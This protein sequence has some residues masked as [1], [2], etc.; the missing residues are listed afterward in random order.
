VAE[1]RAVIRD[2]ELRRLLAPLARTVAEV[3]PEVE[4]RKR[5]LEGRP[6]RVKLGI[7]PTA[8]QVHVG[9]GIPLWNLRRLQDLG[10]VAVLIIGDYTALVGD[11][12]E[13]DKTRPMLT[14]EQVERN[15]ATWLRQIGRILD[16]SRAEVRRNSEWF[17]KMDFL[18]VLSLTNRMTVQQ[19]LARESFSRRMGEGN[20]ISIREFLYCLMQGWDSVQVRADLEIGG[21]DQTFNLNVGRTL[22]EQMG[23]PPQSTLV[24]PMLE[25]TDGSAKMSKSLGNSIGL[26]ESPKDVFGKAM[27][28]PDALLPKWMALATDLEDDEIAR[29]LA[30]GSNPRD[31]KLA[32]AER[33]V[34]RYHG[35]DAGRAER[36]E[37]LRVFHDRLAPTVVPE[38][39]VEAGRHGVVD[40]LVRGT[41]APSRSEAKR[42]VRQGAV[43]I[44]DRVIADEG[45]AIQFGAGDG[46]ATAA[47][48]AA[49]D[50]EDDASLLVAPGA[51]LRAGRR[52]FVR[53][54]LPEEGA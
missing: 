6:L 47:D 51:L 5:L 7:D 4:L 34:A 38:M 36:E 15:V 25:G 13:K 48:D 2:P 9:N 30:P 8:T 26:D 14:P 39:A 33:L 45:Q 29:L 52:R 31:A 3:T 10:H 20:P 24:N 50:D 12:S 53:L 17:S 35:A 27:R 28:I 41:L 22:M 40:L 49:R 19:M 18:D 46:A 42:L 23:L 44:D 43:A 32:L 1:E 11:P 21:T 54:V 16:L 37:F